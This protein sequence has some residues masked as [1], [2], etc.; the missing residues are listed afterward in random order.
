MDPIGYAL[1][2]FDTLGRVRTS[3]ENNGKSINVLATLEEG[4]ELDGAQG[5]KSYLIANKQKFARTL[6]EKL[7]TFALGRGLEYYDECAVRENS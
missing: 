1:E 5:L 4:T 7:L 2:G 6:T 3:Y